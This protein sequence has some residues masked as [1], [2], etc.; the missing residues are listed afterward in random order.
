[1]KKVTGPFINILQTKIRDRETPTEELRRTLYKL[2]EYIATEI[3]GHE[4][5]GK[6]SIITPL[7]Q[8]YQGYIMIQSKKIVI[9][10]RDDY[11]YFA[12]GIADNLPNC[13]RGYMDFDGLRGEEA[14]SSPIRS[15][16]LP[17][18]NKGQHVDTII[19]DKSILATGC[20]AISLLRKSIEK[21]MPSKIIVASAFYSNHGIA[22]LKTE[23]PNC[24]IY[25]CGDAD[26]LNEDMML[27]PGVGNLDNRMK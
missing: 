22:D 19:I 24:K 26:S 11:D 14:L 3:I 1:M 6:K 4:F 7:N 8:E 18:I 2:G 17:D 20:T 12:A 23:V 5:I 25:V 16:E 15:I 21:Y 13:L 27:I 10:T 9:S